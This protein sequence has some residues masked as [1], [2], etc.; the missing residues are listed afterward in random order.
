M[1]AAANLVDAAVLDAALGAT[2]EASPRRLGTAELERELLATIKAPTAT[3]TDPS[4]P[5]AESGS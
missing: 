1:L 4:D 3:D 2:P 5:S